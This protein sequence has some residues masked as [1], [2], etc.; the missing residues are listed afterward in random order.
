MSDKNFKV[1]QGLTVSGSLIHTK[2][3]K[4]GIGTTN[5]DQGTLNVEGKVSASGYRV[6]GLLPKDHLVATT[7]KELSLQ[8]DA[9][10]RHKLSSVS[11]SFDVASG[12]LVRFINTGGGITGVTIGNGGSHA[13]QF[14]ERTG[15]QVRGAISGSEGVW[16]MRNRGIHLDPHSLSGDDSVSNT[17]I[18]SSDD[19]GLQIDATGSISFNTNNS[20]SAISDSTV[21]YKNANDTMVSMYSIGGQGYLAVNP[22]NAN[23]AHDNTLNVEGTISSSDYI[24]TA[25]NITAS[26]DISASGTVYASALNIG[27]GGATGDLVVDGDLSGSAISASSMVATTGSFDNLVL[28]NNRLDIMDVSASNAISASKGVYG[29]YLVLG[30]HG[31]TAYG[32]TMAGSLGMSGGNI[33][34][35]GGD[36]SNVNNITANKIIHYTGTDNDTYLKF[37]EDRTIIYAGGHTVLDY[38]EGPASTFKIDN[39]GKADITIGGGNVFFGGEE[40]SY[41]GKVGIGKTTPT[42]TLEVVGDISSSGN[43]YVSKSIYI[44]DPTHADYGDA[45]LSVENDALT[46]KDKGNIKIA[47]NSDGG[48]SGHKLTIG[49]GSL[50]SANYKELFMISASGDVGIGADV[51]SGQKLTVAG[52][53]SASGNIETTELMIAGTFQSTYTSASVIYTS[54]SSNFGDSQDDFVS[55]TGSMGLSGSGLVAHFGTKTLEDQYIQVRSQG[56]TGFGAFGIDSSLNGNLGGLRIQ[57]GDNKPIYLVSGDSVWGNRTPHM[58]IS[59]SGAVANV[60]I[61]MDSQDAYGLIVSGGLYTV[62]SILT[63]GNVGIGTTSP[64]TNL[65]IQGAESETYQYPLVL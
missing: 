31:G 17:R 5:P 1:K 30:G 53:I 46:L 39:E 27:S 11:Q 44:F 21:A 37:D 57:G 13:D 49:T 60:G 20:G 34:M 63:E 41:D 38:D 14:P 51:S 15:L 8:Y 62:G 19:K 10:N 50:G 42:K 23:A 32:I 58:T 26:G 16:V 61:G 22:N 59:G 4:V 35:S 24:S 65:E 54:G 3:N 6:S 64:T 45:I 7:T 48:H 12:T 29:S 52:N 2:D 56:N 47:F 18:Y 40:G 28:T 9:D 33:A 43:L 36:I 25:T 55:I